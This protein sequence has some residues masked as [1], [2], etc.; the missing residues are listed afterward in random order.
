MVTAPATE[1]S[2]FV[3][4]LLDIK[5]VNDVREMLTEQRNIHIG[6]VGTSTSDITCMTDVT[7]IGNAEA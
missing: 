7:P 6:V 2:E 1:R 5:D 3:E 4:K